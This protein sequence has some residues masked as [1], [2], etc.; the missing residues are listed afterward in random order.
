MPVHPL[1]T[2][3]TTPCTKDPSPMPLALSVVL[4]AHNEVGVIETVIADVVATARRLA[5]DDRFEVIVVDDASTDGTSGVLDR[6]SRHEPS[7]VVV[8]LAD[9]VGHGPALRRG[10]EQASAPWVAHLDS[11]AEIPA[12]QLDRVWALRE[13]ADLVLGTRR[14][15]AESAVRRFVTWSLKPIALAASRQPLRDANTPCKLVRRRFLDDALTVMPAGAFAPSVLLAVVV[16]RR[17]G[18]IVEVAVD[19]EPRSHGTSWLVP[20][21]LLRGCVH[22]LLDTARV[23]WRTR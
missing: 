21:T 6:L 7:L 1:A 14:G 9:N 13:D 23:A 3:H 12:H 4:P 10:W 11:D 2:A 17:G 22:S 20:T 8:H 18:R 16:A 5:G 15:R 19:T